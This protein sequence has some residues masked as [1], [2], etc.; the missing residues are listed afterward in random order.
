LWRAERT[1]ELNRLCRRGWC[2][3]AVQPHGAKTGRVTHRLAAYA[4]ASKSDVTGAGVAL[5]T[6]SY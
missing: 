6:A 5:P 1:A 3:L 2:R 4:K